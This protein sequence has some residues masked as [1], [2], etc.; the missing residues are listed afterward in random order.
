MDDSDSGSA[1]GD[2]PEGDIPAGSTSS[3]RPQQ[4]IGG[5]VRDPREV[6]TNPSL[7]RFLR[8][9]MSAALV[10]GLVSIG[11]LRPTPSGELGP[12]TEGSAALVAGSSPSCS[13]GMVH[14]VPEPW[15][16][17]TLGDLASRWSRLYI[18]PRSPP[19][20]DVDAH[21]NYTMSLAGR[22]LAE[23][24]D[25]PSPCSVV[26]RERQRQRD[27]ALPA[28][29]EAGD[30][31]VPH[32]GRNYQTQIRPSAQLHPHRLHALRRR[33]AA[34]SAWDKVEDDVTKCMKQSRP[35]AALQDF[36]M[37]EVTLASSIRAAVNAKVTS[38]D[39]AAAEVRAGHRV[40]TGRHHRIQAPQPPTPSRSWRA[41]VWRRRSC[42]T[43]RACRPSFRTR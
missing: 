8:E 18:T 21:V 29:P 28:R 17:V 10:S 31:C 41:A 5:M 40:A 43:V 12:A 22:R 32:A 26:T 4:P 20:C 13:C 6:K 24:P 39:G 27:S 38:A 15:L 3:A 33:H 30:R 1:E 19:V 42:A 9:R 35:A 34:T 2:S 25:D 37:R 11:V 14:I 36:Q 7:T 16:P 23:E